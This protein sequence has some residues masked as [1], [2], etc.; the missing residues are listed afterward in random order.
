L[1]LSHLALSIFTFVQIIVLSSLAVRKFLSWQ[2]KTKTPKSYL[3]D[4]VDILAEMKTE[5][6]QG[7]GYA[8]EETESSPLTVHTGF[9]TGLYSLSPESDIGPGYHLFHKGESSYLVYIEDYT[10]YVTVT[11]V[12]YPGIYGQ[13]K[14]LTQALFDFSQFGT[15]QVEEQIHQKSLFEDY[16]GAAITK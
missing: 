4:P 12:L 11:A 3:V 10:S 14:T 2:R 16:W 1:N 7:Y 13:G 8:A 15:A 9:T 5:F 6:E